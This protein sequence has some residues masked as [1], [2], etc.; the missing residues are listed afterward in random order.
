MGSTEIINKTSQSVTLKVGNN[1]VFTDLSVLK[2]GDS[3]KVYVD[4]NATYQEYYMGKDRTGGVLLIS[5]DDCIDNKSITI[6][7]EANGSYTLQ[8]QSR[9]SN[10]NRSGSPAVSAADSNSSR[11]VGKSS[12][13]S[14][15]FTIFSSRQ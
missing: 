3:Y 9:A 10:A 1:S 6:V 5:S 13:L 11:S 8:K 15:L 2:P 14:G 12:R 7:E 4:P